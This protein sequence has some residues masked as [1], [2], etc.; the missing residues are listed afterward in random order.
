MILK[1][2]KDNVASEN[3][4]AVT[5]E[6]IVVVLGIFLGM[7]VT[8]WNEDRKERDEEQVYLDRLHDD[9]V[10]QVEEMNLRMDY[11]GKAMIDNRIV[12]D[13]LT[14]PKTVSHPTPRI[15]AAFYNS[16]VIYPFAPFS[17]TYEE[18]LSTGKTPILRDLALRKN[19][20]KYFYDTEPLMN[21]WNI[22][23][24]NNYRELIRGEMPY[25]FQM[26]AATTCEPTPNKMIADCA[27]DVEEA[28]AKE[29]LEEMRKVKGI[30]RLATLNLTRLSIA[31]RLYRENQGVAQQMKDQLKTASS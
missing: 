7:Q 31:L 13:Y 3:W 25:R 8:E 17:L 9:M 2:L 14:D 16:S 26:M 15:L 5:V 6:I 10:T 27:I 28:A 11:L 24:D 29:A 21:A 22:D 19:I 1:R 20:A 30:K 12:V 18:L 23:N 4:F